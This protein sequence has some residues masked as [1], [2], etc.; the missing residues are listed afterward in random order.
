MVREQRQHEIA[1]AYDMGLVVP[2]VKFIGNEDI[3]LDNSWYMAIPGKLII[4]K[5]PGIDVS[6]SVWW[7]GEKFSFYT[8]VVSDP[9]MMNGGQG[10]ALESNI[11][12]VFPGKIQCLKSPLSKLAAIIRER[13]PY[14]KGFVILDVILNDQKAYYKR[15]HFGT[16]YDIIYAMGTLVDMNPD[17]LIAFI[18]RDGN[19]KKP[20]GFSA[21]LRLYAYPYEPDLN[22]HV[23]ISGPEIKAHRGPE[24]FFLTEKGRTIRETWK[25]IYKHT[26]G[27]QEYGVCYRTDGDNKARKVFNRLKREHYL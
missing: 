15:I 5:I 6:L 23:V 10:P 9:Y 13:E 27:L 17:D 21:S 26:Y 14:Y 25:K 8:V 7:D 12:T 16:T 1:L 24:C 18:E 4:K 11:I 20:E 19:M 22:F 2:D 3:E